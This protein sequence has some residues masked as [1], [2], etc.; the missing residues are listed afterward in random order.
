ME[1]VRDVTGLTLVLDFTAAILAE[2][3]PRDAL[4]LDG[5]AT[6]LREDLGGGLKPETIGLPDA[7]EIASGVVSPKELA[8]L[9][10]R[11]A[12]LDLDEAIEL[13][14][15]INAVGGQRPRTLR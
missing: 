2:R 9:V 1:A 6:R 10:R 12:A 5:A 15:S 7:R 4:L 8:E 3:N 14:R 13:A 11:G